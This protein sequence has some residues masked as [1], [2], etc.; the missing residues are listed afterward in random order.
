[1]YNKFKLLIGLS[2]CFWAVTIRNIWIVFAES[3]ISKTQNI[4][5]R[6]S[7]FILVYYRQRNCSVGDEATYCIYYDM[8]KG[9]LLHG[10]I[11]AEITLESRKIDKPPLF[12][13]LLLWCNLKH[14][15]KLQNLSIFIFLLCELRF[16]TIGNRL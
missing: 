13:H 3:K 12:L 2:I 9:N 16:L 7:L 5:K 8:R 14:Q 11:T 4:W 10:R 15:L 1:M 6:F